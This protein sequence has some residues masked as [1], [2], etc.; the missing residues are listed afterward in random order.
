MTNDS[1]LKPLDPVDHRRPRSGPSRAVPPL[2]RTRRARGR[3]VLGQSVVTFPS[4]LP[5]EA[6]ENPGG[7]CSPVGPPGAA[8]WDALDRG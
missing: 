8:G 4:D 1:G 2:A 3:L 5:L 7:G 6:V